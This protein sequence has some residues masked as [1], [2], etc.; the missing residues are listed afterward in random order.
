MK[1]FSRLY[2]NSGALGL[3]INLIWPSPDTANTLDTRDTP[4]LPICIYSPT[5]KNWY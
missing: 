3:Y 1:S 4:E 2:P 5:L